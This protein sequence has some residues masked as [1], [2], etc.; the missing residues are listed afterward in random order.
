MT[1]HYCHWP[2]QRKLSLTIVNADQGNSFAN[3]PPV[4]KSSEIQLTQP[5]LHFGPC[6]DPYDVPG[7]WTR[8]GDDVTRNYYIPLDEACPAPPNF[9]QDVAEQAPL[10][11]LQ[12][13]TVL[14]IGDSVDSNSYTTFCR[15]WPASESNDT[16][17]L[18][19]LRLLHLDEEV[20]SKA[21]YRR[22][23]EEHGPARLL[24]RIQH[25]GAK[26][27]LGKGDARCGEQAIGDNC[28]DKVLCG[29]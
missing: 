8:N 23:T 28:S 25:D 9:L 5:S 29:S 18:D 12:G 16:T 6:G 24:R 26:E 11:F 4:T 27:E 14:F 10:S 2:L 22:R 1:E 7:V 20:I 21:R 13:R 3:A 17:V 19:R 15:L